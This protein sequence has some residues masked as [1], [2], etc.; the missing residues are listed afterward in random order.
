MKKAIQGLINLQREKYP[1]GLFI[2][3][4][5]FT[6]VD[7]ADKLIFQW[8]TDF[9]VVSIYKNFSVFNVPIES[10]VVKNFWKIAIRIQ[11]ESLTVLWRGTR[12]GYTT[13]IYSVNKKQRPGRNQV[14]RHQ[15]DHES[16]DWLPRSLWP[17]SGI[18]KVFFSSIFYFVALQLMLHMM[19]HSFTGYVLLFGRNV[20]GYLG[21]VCCFLTTR[22]LFTSPTSHRLLFSTQ[23]SPNWTI[24]H[25]LQISYLA[26]IICSQVWRIFF[27]T[28]ILWTIMTVNHYLES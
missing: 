14:K 2:G 3:K 4:T 22:H 21:V 1:R 16:H 15:P 27:M 17:S 18:I 28:G 24:L 13:T 11:L 6:R 20:V 10:T 5:V 25:I 7:Y 23:I 19:H 12:H 26:S 9:L 8:S